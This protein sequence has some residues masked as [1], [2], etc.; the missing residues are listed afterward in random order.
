MDIARIALTRHTC[1]AY[2]P[3]RKIAEPQVEQIKTLLR[4]ARRRLNSQPWRS[5][6]ARMMAKRVW[7]RR[8]AKD[9]TR[10][11]PSRCSMRRMSSC[12]VSKPTS[13]M[14]LDALLAQE[15]CDGRF[16]TPEHMAM[17]DKGRHF[18]ADLHRVT[19][20]DT[21]AW[22]ARQVYLAL[23]NLLL[24]A[25]T[26][27]IDATPIEGYDHVVLDQELG[28]PGQGFKSLVMVALGYRSA[29]DYNAD[30]A[31]VALAR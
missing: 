18:Y 26:L 3:T 20:K 22:M 4:Y 27:G 12:S 25:T 28:L 7:P 30:C 29:E 23:G 19:Q 10:R 14:S 2:D 6:P 31:Q 15:N 1:K 8:R 21:A 11:M 16:L 5:S 9:P 24:G 17:Q 13:M